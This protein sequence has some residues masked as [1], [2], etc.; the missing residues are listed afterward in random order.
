MSKKEAG[1]SAS[2]LKGKIMVNL[3]SPGLKIIYYIY[4]WIAMTE[5][6]R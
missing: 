1:K 3:L 4:M 6:I 5:A 2:F